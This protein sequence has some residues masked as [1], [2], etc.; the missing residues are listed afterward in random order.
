MRPASALTA[1]DGRGCELDVATGEQ[2]LC[3]A[4]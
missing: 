2:G 4:R 1:D 3:Y